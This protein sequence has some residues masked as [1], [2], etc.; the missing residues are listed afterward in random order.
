MIRDHQDFDLMTLERFCSDTSRFSVERKRVKG[1]QIA[2]TRD[3]AVGIRAIAARWL[4]HAQRN[5]EKY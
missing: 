2:E 5:A 4:P 3:F 1:G